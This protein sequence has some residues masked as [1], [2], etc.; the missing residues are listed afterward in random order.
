M[1]NY[2]TANDVFLH[3]P[4]T[5]RDELLEF[6]AEKAVEQGAATDKEALLQAFLD[7][8]ATESCGLVS[9]VAVPHAKC[10]CVRCPCVMVVRCD[11]E[12]AWE[13][14]DHAP[15]R[16]AVAIMVPDTDA[17]TPY[18]RLLAKAAVM[19]MDDDFVERV[20]ALDDPAEVAAAVNQGLGA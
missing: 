16:C 3:C 6:V 18:L 15:V 4:A 11:N 8:E 17:G 1:G 20:R 14:M 5:T 12:L 19:L 13:T 10:A 9:G 7:R 2:I